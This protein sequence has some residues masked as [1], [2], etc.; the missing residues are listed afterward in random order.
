MG[1]NPILKKGVMNTTCRIHYKRAGF[2]ERAE[3][4]KDTIT[5]S[6]HGCG[7]HTGPGSQG[8]KM[9]VGQLAPDISVQPRGGVGTQS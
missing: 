9:L 6:S 2:T 4:A 7:D 3:Q 5:S 8:G 1:K